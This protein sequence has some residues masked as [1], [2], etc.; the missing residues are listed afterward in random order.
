MLFGVGS[1]VLLSRGSLVRKLLVAGL[2]AATL[3]SG[4][5]GA[6][7][8]DRALEDPVAVPSASPT[9]ASTPSPDPTRTPLLATPGA[10]AP[11]PTTVGLTRALRV[12][13]KDKG[14]GRAVALSVLDV[15]TGKVLLEQDPRRLLTP[16]STT[17][18]ATAVAA[19]KVLGP[20]ARFTTRV[21]AGRAQ[22]VVLVGGGDPTLTARAEPAYP[23]P[24]RLADLAK[25]LAGREVRRVVV[26]ESLF[27]GPRLGPAWKSSYV[28][29]GDV[30]PVSALE[31]DEGRTST[32]PGARRVSD[33]AMDAGRDLA[34]LLKVRAVVRGTAPAKAEVLASVQSPPVSALV[35]EM[36]S[37]SDNDLAEALGR[38]VAL[39][40]GEPASFTGEARAMRRVLGPFLQRAGVSPDLLAL[41]DASGL[42]RDSRI[43][44][45]A[46]TRLLAVAARDPRYAAVLTGL[47]VA[48]FDGT[49]AE[50][51]RKAPSSTAAGEVRAKTGS[52]SGVSALAGLVRTADGRLLSF[53]VIADGIGAT[54]RAQRALDRVAATVA[55]CGC[56]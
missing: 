17:K 12:P 39:A 34:K 38:H 49:L 35:E 53:A 9:P 52:L 30:A 27:E 37:R 24:A 45:A 22:D 32:R 16:A 26:D 10:D 21:V 54:A 44:P 15:R 1:V 6:V 7:L 18:V 55:A 3:T 43:A 50:R 47:P 48:G 23:Q 4:V 33:P 42:S 25:A 14:L 56:R 36:L 5:G 8:V 20:D 46:L 2:A 19:L 41:R 31:V 28:T 51:F 29:D 13:L 11:L 40:V